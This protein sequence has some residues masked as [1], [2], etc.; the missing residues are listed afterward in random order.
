MTPLAST[1]LSPV[2][3]GID[4]AEP[5]A[6]RTVLSLMRW[7]DDGV[8]AECVA[9]IPLRDLRC[10]REAETRTCS[11]LIAEAA[12]R[13]RLAMTAPPERLVMLP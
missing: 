6:D 10:Y 4:V 1:A 5:G 3:I 12:L 13:Y 2:S 11:R 9:T 7:R 8:Q